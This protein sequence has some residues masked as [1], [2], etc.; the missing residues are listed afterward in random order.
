MKQLAFIWCRLASLASS[1]TCAEERR[2]RRAFE[3]KGARITA[4]M[5]ATMQ[6]RNVEETANSIALEYLSIPIS[7]IDV[8]R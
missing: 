6:I 2:N 7:P 8:D 1:S 3:A 5:T 4:T